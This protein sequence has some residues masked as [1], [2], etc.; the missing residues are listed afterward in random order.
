MFLRPQRPLFV[1]GNAYGI[2]FHAQIPSLAG[3]H[4]GGL[5]RFRGTLFGGLDGRAEQTFFPIRLC[6]APA[7][8]NP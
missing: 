1:F 4:I 3:G 8:A 5:A 7:L 6:C 2:T